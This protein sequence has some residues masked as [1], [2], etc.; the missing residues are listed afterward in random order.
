MMAPRYLGAVNCE[1]HALP[2]NHERHRPLDDIILQMVRALKL[3][4]EYRLSRGQ[5]FVTD[6]YKGR[7]V[8]KTPPRPILAMNTILFEDVSNA[9]SYTHL[10][11][12][13]AGSISQSPVFGR[14]LGPGGTDLGAKDVPPG[15][16]CAICLY[17]L[18]QEILA[19]NHLEQQE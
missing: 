13:A 17:S 6:V 2:S 5:S 16:G 7:G 8:D 9:T 12:A 15:P 1:V 4:Q 14:Q 18:S 19:P 10:E 3:E 11:L